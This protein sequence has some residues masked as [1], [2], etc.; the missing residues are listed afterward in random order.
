MTQD[1][2]IQ[3]ALN[4]MHAVFMQSDPNQTR[5]SYADAHGLP[6]S[7]DWIWT[8]SADDIIRGENDVPL[9]PSVGGCDGV[10]KVF[11]HFARKVK[12]D[13]NVLVTVRNED[14]NGD[15]KH[16]N[17]HQIIAVRDEQTGQLRAF[18]PGKYRELQYINRPIGVNRIIDFEMDGRII[19][20]TITAIISP[21]EH[22]N[23]KKYSQLHDLYVRGQPAPNKNKA[24]GFKQ[25]KQKLNLWQAMWRKIRR[26]ND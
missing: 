13:C 22:A 10:V 18:E 7:G 19:P 25:G 26:E 21:Q 16:L 9:N 11:C 1:E 23:I 17:G 6:P 12:L 15:R 2:K 4:D 5:Q 8:L 3:S 24:S 20:H 14:L